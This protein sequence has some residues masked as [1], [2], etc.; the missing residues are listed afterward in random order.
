MKEQKLTRKD[1]A[2]G[3]LCIVTA[4]LERRSPPRVQQHPGSGCGLLAPNVHKLTVWPY[5][6]E[7]RSIAEK[8]SRAFKASWR[9]GLHRRPAGTSNDDTIRFLDVSEDGRPTL[10][11]AAVAKPFQRGPVPPPSNLFETNPLRIRIKKKSEKVFI[12][13]ST[14]SRPS[15]YFCLQPRSD[16]ACARG[17]RFCNKKINKITRNSFPPLDGK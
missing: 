14:D 15:I 3:K 2:T 4:V 13:A 8:L 6:S 9:P 17:Q 12:A 5:T 1:K 7:V 11:L 16:A 10:K